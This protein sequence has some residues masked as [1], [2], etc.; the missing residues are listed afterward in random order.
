MLLAFLQIGLPIAAGVLL[1]VTGTILTPSIAG[2][3]MGLSSVGVMAN[4]L[5]LRYKFSLEQERRYKRSAGTKTNR[6]SNIM[7]DKS[8]GGK[9][10]NSDGRWKGA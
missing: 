7:M 9:H 1:P 2:A 3:L 4:S 10:P 5:F 6:V 8:V